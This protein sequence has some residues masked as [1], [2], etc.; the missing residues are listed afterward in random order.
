MT[1][2]KISVRANVPGVDSDHPMLH[3]FRN[4]WLKFTAEENF[5]LGAKPGDSGLSELQSIVIDLYCGQHIVCSSMPTAKLLGQVELEA[6]FR[7][8]GRALAEMFGMTHT[9][10]PKEVS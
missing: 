1:V 7:A 4:R 10:E 6:L 2:N 9:V 5:L 8:R 3:E